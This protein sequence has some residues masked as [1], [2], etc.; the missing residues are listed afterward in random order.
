M[1]AKISVAVLLGGDSSERSVSL[2]SGRAVAEALDPARFAVTCFD[3]NDNT[4]IESVALPS[5]LGERPSCPLFPLAWK[6]LIV[7]L[8][9]NGFDVVFPVL[10]G[11]RGEDGTLQRLLEVAGLKYV[12]SPARA[13][14]IAIDKPLAKSYL[15]TFGLPSP[16]G[17][18]VSSLEELGQHD[19]PFPCVVK[20]AGGGSSVG[21][22]ILQSS[23]GLQEAVGKSLADGSGALIEEFIPGIEVT[24][25]VMGE[26]DNARA[27]PAIEIVPKLGDGFYDF[28]AKYAKGG[29]D[30]LIP[31]R[32]SDGLQVEV[33]GMALRAHQLL[34]CRG[35]TRS[36][37]LVSDERG[38][39]YLET[40]T[41]P[42]MTA[43]SL[44]PD[45]ARA[46]GFDF[47]KLVAK[48]VEDALGQNT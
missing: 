26:G 19:I 14:T 2:S 23:E 21:V 30:H 46:I 42:G 1:N 31:P 6:D 38:A 25:T 39:I 40:N 27:L 8:D 12:G 41:S 4:S 9:A 22:T 44:V 47:P 37:F 18:F 5:P 35:V 13:C 36:D 17:F 15:S 3:V 10:H 7:A 45:A 33:A 32:I 11:G 34:G 48:L 29:S 28:E 43:T 16:R 20:P 24:C